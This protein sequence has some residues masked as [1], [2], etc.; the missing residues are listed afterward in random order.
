MN[1][2]SE[3]RLHQI[4]DMDSQIRELQNKK[5]KLQ[6]ENKADDTRWQD[7]RKKKLAYEKQMIHAIG[8][9]VDSPVITTDQT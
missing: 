1:T 3:A 2:R 8:Y 6:E 4:A 7:W 9:F 5:S